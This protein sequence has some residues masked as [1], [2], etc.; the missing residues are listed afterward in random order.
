MGESVLHQLWIEQYRPKKF[1]EIRGQEK[2]V[3]RVKA[4]VKQGNLSHLLLA[5]PPGCGK[6]TLIL[7]AA[8]ELYGDNWR[9][10]VL[11]TNASTDRGIDVVR[12]TIKDFARTKAIGGSQFKIAILDEADALTKDAQNALRRTME[13]FS[14][15]CRFVLIANY[16]SK[17][18]E[19]IQSRCTVFRF[20]PL[21]KKDLR[22]ILN[23]I[24]EVEKLKI[25]EK[26]LDAIFYVC[27]GDARKAENILQSCAV[28]DKHITEKSVYE[29]ASLAEPKEIKEVL[30]VA[31]GGDFVKARDKLLDTMLKYGLSGLDVIKQ[32][33]KEI[34]NLN[35]KNDSKVKLVDKCG[36]IEFRMVEG[37]DEYLQ[38]EALLALFTITK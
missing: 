6:T 30:E 26:A 37:S 2:I 13:Q 12:E 20:K 25:D 33:Q 16:S 15:T 36:E 24:A 18:I 3:E 17:I 34:W 8:R 38:L 11:E 21:E 32:I 19:P 29:M 4:M 23:H 1:S 35:I 10:N 31:V 28:M 5:G 27:E 7:V 9:D 22:D 14:N